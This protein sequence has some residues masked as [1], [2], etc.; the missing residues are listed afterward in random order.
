MPSTVAT[1]A[2]I[3][4]RQLL[5]AVNEAYQD[6][7][8]PVHMSEKTFMTLI[9][10]ESA[11][12]ANSPVAIQDKRV[13][14][15]VLLGRRR[16]RGW[17]GGVGV[18]PPCRKKGIASQLLSEAIRRAEVLGVRSLQLE[19]VLENEAA[20]RLYE[21]SGFTLTR[22]LFVMSSEGGSGYP[23]YDHLEGIRHF[24]P[25][26]RA[27]S[28]EWVAENSPVTLPWQREKDALDTE[29][30]SLRGIALLDDNP[31]NLLGVCLYQPANDDI[32]IK[33]LIASDE[34]AG[35]KLLGHL[36]RR[37]P[38]TF[39][40]CLNIPEDDPMVPVFHR[41]GYK[42]VLIQREMRLEIGHTSR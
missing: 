5:D 15:V 1:A 31:E 29:R 12:L 38:W 9:R 33:A 2:E 11:D 37:H 27:L 10:R 4:F 42:I 22:D 23:R 21:R 20:I 16:D 14:G 39:S 40:S 24:K 3:P 36:Q 28:L 30:Q 6:Y 41:Q 25:G 35:D 19:V 7:F 26:R 34:D 8:V 13:V 17:I 18:I 32:D